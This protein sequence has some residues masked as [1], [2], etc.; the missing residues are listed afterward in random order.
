MKK[1]RW[2]NRKKVT[3]KKKMMFV[4]VIEQNGYIERKIIDLRLVVVVYLRK[5]LRLGQES[6]GRPS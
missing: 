1:R 6:T 2:T 3:N 5:C 4:P